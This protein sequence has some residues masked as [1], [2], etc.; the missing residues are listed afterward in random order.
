MSGVITNSRTSGIRVQES[1]SH[2]LYMLVTS[3]TFVHA[4]SYSEWLDSLFLV[5]MDDGTYELRSF[6]RFSQ[7]SRELAVTSVEVSSTTTLFQICR[8]TGSEG[9][10]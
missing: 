9:F 6:S 4:Y 8:W 3:S 2:Y 1:D 5:V 10:F 7:F